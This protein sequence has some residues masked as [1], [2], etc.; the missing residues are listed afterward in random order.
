MKLGIRTI[1]ICIGLAIL[2]A[3][4]GITIETQQEV[5]VDNSP[6]C[7]SAAQEVVAQWYLD[8]GLVVENATYSST[9]CI[10]MQWD[11][12]QIGLHNLTAVGSNQNGSFNLS[13]N[14]TVLNTIIAVKAIRTDLSPLNLTLADNF[15]GRFYLD[16]VMVQENLTPAKNHYYNKW[17][18]YTEIGDHYLR[19][20]GEKPAIPE[21]GIPTLPVKWGRKIF[22]G[23]LFL[24]NES[25]PVV[26]ITVK[27]LLL[28]PGDR[29]N[30]TTIADV[31]TLDIPVQ[32]VHG[33]TRT[34]QQLLNLSAYQVAENWTDVNSTREV[35]RSDGKNSTVINTTLF[36]GNNNG[37]FYADLMSPA[38]E[39]TLGSYES[40]TRRIPV[41]R[42]KAE[43]KVSWL[44][45]P[46][47]NFI[48][49]DSAEVARMR[50][51]AFANGGAG[52]NVSDCPPDDRTCPRYDNNR[53]GKI[54]Q[55]DYY[56]L[57]AQRTAPVPVVS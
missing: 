3:A 56:G 37:T 20:V 8:G 22:V 18:N 53:S 28:A 16:D 10:E 46:N 48:T 39:Y 32:L 23:T 44:F 5:G 2:P 1:L 38:V 35:V 43:I 36:I 31:E 21:Q 40:G 6:F 26:N 25:V 13:W 9:H 45:D 17:W 19:F 41:N 15:T 57:L 42:A 7:L 30:L 4:A 34:S 50:Q 29:A 12:S 47:G 33:M 11:E 49:R 52:T 27:S 51:L 14:V 24:T 55:N 54:D